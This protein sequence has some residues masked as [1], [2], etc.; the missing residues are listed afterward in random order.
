MEVHNVHPDVLA[1]VYKMKS[2]EL[3]SNTIG[4]ASMAL[5]VDPPRRGREADATV[6]AYE[7]EH[8]LIFDSLKA[9]A[10]TLSRRL[11]QMKNVR[12]Q[13]WR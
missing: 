2:I 9:R 12:R 10:T 8:A 4:Q 7:R 5:K 13:R 3:C 11:N 1:Q 6:D